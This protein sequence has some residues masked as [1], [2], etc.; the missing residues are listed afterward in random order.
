MKENI[1][2]SVFILVGLAGFF[3]FKNY[4]RKIKGKSENLIFWLAQ[5]S[6]MQF[7]F[8]ILILTS[9]DLVNQIYRDELNIGSWQYNLF[10]IL[11][12]AINS[13]LLLTFYICFISYY[14]KMIDEGAKSSDVENQENLSQKNLRTLN[15][16]KNSLFAITYFLILFRVL[17]TE[18]DYK[19]S[20]LSVLGNIAF[21]FIFPF[22]FFALSAVLSGLLC[23]AIFIL[24]LPAR[25]L[26]RLVFRV[27]E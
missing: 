4:F 14:K 7:L 18:I 22:C 16:L 27:I 12:P 26:T 23:I 21:S 25:I 19:D 6:L 10:P 8:S 2:L 11:W 9:Y 24:I 20:F 17:I 5:N 3:H 13:L 15:M 1:I